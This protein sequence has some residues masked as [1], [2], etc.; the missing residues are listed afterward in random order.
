MPLDCRIWLEGIAGSGKTSAAVRR[1]LDLL[2]SG[3]PAES[4]LIFVPQRSLAQPYIR[5]LR[6][7]TSHRGGQVSAH[8]IGSLSLQLVE[9]FWFL[10]AGDAGFK[11]PQDLPNFLSLELVQY[12]MTRAIE[13]L[14]E[15]RDYFSSV[16][17]DRPRLYSQIVDNMNKAALVGFPINEIGTRLKSA[18]ASGVEQAH[19]YDDAQSCAMAF[20]K[21]CLEHN[22]L[23]FSL[24]LEVFREHVWRTPQARAYLRGRYRHLIVDGVEEDNPASHEFVGDLLEICQSALIVCDRDAGF[25]RFL[26]ADPDSARRL[27][28]RCEEK[29]T[30]EDSFVMGA[31]VSALGAAL[32][33]QLGVADTAESAADPRRALI[34]EAHRYHPEMVDW[35]ATQVEALVHER[36]ASPNEIVILAP[37]LSDALRFGL[38]DGL[39]RRGIPLRTHRPSRALRDEPAA[40]TLLT[41]AR[42][43]HPHWRLPPSDFDVAFALMAA[44]DGLDLVRA[45]LLTEMLYRGERLL[46]FAEVRSTAMQERITFDLGERYD[47]L[48]NWLN[49]YIDG[50]RADAIDIFFRR[51]FGGLLAR[52]GFGFH[53]NIDAGNIS[54]NLVDSA[55]EFR[56]SLDFMSRYDAQIDLGLDYVRMVDRGVIANSYLRDWIA[57]VEEGVLIA[58]AYTFLLNNRP[59]DYQFWLNIGSEGWSRRLYQPL[60]HPYVLSRGWPPG[61]LWSEDDEGA[62]NR[63]TLGRLLLALT[64][65]CRKAVYLGYS[66]LSESGYEPRGLLLETIQSLLRRLA[67]EE[68]H[69]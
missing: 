44:I 28:E 5:A 45:K 20:R 38:V 68:Q 41:L 59:V 49:R 52:A 60:T 39:E 15:E 21:Y 29:A 32:A 7:L 40:R 10:I 11:H 57:D 6:G 47:R 46:P 54:M 24:Q 14:V 16:R 31:E 25:R 30:F 48:A 33:A 42:L 34:T 4:I 43:A 66:E 62:M 37:F 53:D 51:I 61:V 2:A 9:T 13:P 3:V 50:G 56:W 67:R 18:L 22:L 64:R 17:I 26:G 69:V 35:V 36:G 63:L 23:D 19:I 8:T 55:R 27:R 1:V 12:F 65:R 58:P